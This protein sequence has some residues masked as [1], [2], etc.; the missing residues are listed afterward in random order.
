MGLRLMGRVV[1]NGCGDKYAEGTLG[2]LKAPGAAIPGGE[3]EAEGDDVGDADDEV[4]TEEIGA[5]IEVA[6]IASGLSEDRA[7]REDQS[8]VV[9]GAVDDP[10]GELG[11]PVIVADP[12]GGGDS[13][14]V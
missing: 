6:P 1:C 5:T 4:K 9:S 3:V 2:E 7:N 14:Q 8:I 12:P 11:G 13:A 10:L